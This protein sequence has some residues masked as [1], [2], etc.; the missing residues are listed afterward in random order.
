MSDLEGPKHCSLKKK[1]LRDTLTH[2]GVWARGE[3]GVALQPPQNL[4]DLDFLG[5]KRNL[6]KANF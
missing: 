1:V 4:G 6:G 2:I 5:S 3:R